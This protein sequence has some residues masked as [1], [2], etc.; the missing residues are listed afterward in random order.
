MP[1][2]LIL[3]GTGKVGRRTARILEEAGHTARV[4]GRST[5]MRF[6]WNAPET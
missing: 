1:T 5:R 6:D 2:F 4:V 3:G